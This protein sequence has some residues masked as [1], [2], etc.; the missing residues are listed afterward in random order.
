M[1]AVESMVDPVTMVI[2]LRRRKKRSFRRRSDQRV[3]M[4][5]STLTADLAGVACLAVDAGTQ[6][7]LMSATIS[8]P[9]LCRSYGAGGACC[10]LLIVDVNR[11]GSHQLAIFS[12]DC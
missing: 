2:A 9:H 4:R 8:N 7:T 12:S 1:V 6:F 3:C 11:A 5:H 10:R